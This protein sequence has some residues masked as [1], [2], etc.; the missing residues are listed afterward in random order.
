VGGW[1]RLHNEELHNLYTSP[2]IIRVIIQMVR[3]WT[4]YISC[5]EMRNI[6]KIL[7]GKPEGKR[8]LGRPRHR[9]EY[10]I[11]MDLRETECEGVHWMHLDHDRDHW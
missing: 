2:N 7:V 1:R 11:R 10:N 6:N 9:W 5:M 4:G 8:P 3:R